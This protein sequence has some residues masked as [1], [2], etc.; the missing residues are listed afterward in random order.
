MSTLVHVVEKYDTL[1]SIAERYSVSVHDIVRLNNLGANRYICIG[2]QLIIS[3]ATTSTSEVY[4]GMYDSNNVGF[5]QFGI[6]SDSGDTMIVRWKWNRS[7]TS[8]F[9][10][11]WL[12]DN[13]T[14]NWFTGKEER[15]SSGVIEKTSTYKIPWNAVRVK[16]HIRP[17]SYVYHP[18]G[19]ETSYWQAPWTSSNECYVN[20]EPL[21]TPPVPVVSIDGYK[22]TAKIVGYSNGDEMQFQIIQNDSKVY[23]SVMVKN[24][25]TI[26]YSCS[27]ADGYTYKVRCRSKKYKIYSEWSNYSAS[28]STKPAIPTGLDCIALSETSVRLSWISSSSSTSYDIQYVTEIN[29]FN[30]PE[31]I[32]SKNNVQTVNYELTGLEKG[33]VYYF[34]IRGVNNNGN[35]DW[36]SVKN[37]MTGTTPA[38]PTTWSSTTGIVGGKI[39]LIWLHS[40]KDNSKETAVELEL[41]VNG[42][43]NTISLS[44]NLSAGVK[45]VYELNTSSYPDKTTVEWRARTKGVTSDWGDWSI[46]RSVDLH[47]A[48]TLVIN[49]TNVDG[50]VTNT[51]TGFPFHIKGECGPVTQE[52]ISYNVTI[53]AN[54]TYQTWDD[55]GESKTIT[56]GTEVFSKVID[57]ADNQTLDFTLT[58]ASIDLENYISYTVKCIVTMDSGLQAEDDTIINIRW[59]NIINTPNAEMFID[60]NTLSMNIRP[61]CDYYPMVFY[62]VNYNSSTG[63]YVRTNNIL[64]DV[65]G[66]SIEGAY[67]EDYD[68]VVYKGTKYIAGASKSVYFCIAQSDIPELLKNITLSVY[69]KEYDGR[70]IEISSGL[71]NTD[72]TFITDPHPTLDYARY[73]VIAVNDISG[74]MTYTDIPSFFVGETAVIIQWD[75]VWESLE[76]SNE[77]AGLAISSWGGSM[78]R[79]PY[80]IDISDANSQDVSLVNYIGRSYPVTYYGTQLGITSTWDMVIPKKDKDTL[81]G[82]RRLMTYMGDVYVREPSGSGYWA[83]ISVSFSQKH[84]EV[85]VPISLEVTRVEGGI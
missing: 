57:I 9:Q 36:S 37:G 55:F 51:I 47:K 52:P 11:K 48:P 5:Q 75:E 78:L 29:N 66:T 7:E 35:S 80:N 16:V 81:Y 21:P 43:T 71:V 15:V 3:G 46:K 31:L 73:R 10:I 34:R 19:I 64:N 38:A 50:G 13:G 42:Q 83:N 56:T 39:D 17:Y 76:P 58:P 61:Y 2:Q 79:L 23:K 25:S 30:N 33:Q 72:R 14:G 40:S 74:E 54:E 28:Y 85:A 49:T 20:V 45:H 70:F 27:I 24:N 18:Y 22:L 32:F 12:Y 53:V 59:D 26:S 82:L 69:R 67:T 8:H 6:L 1:D 63:K 65:D 41:T 77:S 68:D 4:Q 62:E 44:G 60:K 84:C